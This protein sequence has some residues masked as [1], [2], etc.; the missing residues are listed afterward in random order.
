MQKSLLDVFVNNSNLQC[1][2]TKLM[3]VVHI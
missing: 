3:P 1:S 2:P